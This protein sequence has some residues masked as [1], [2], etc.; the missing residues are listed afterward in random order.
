M[1]AV[2]TRSYSEPSALLKGMA[3]ALAFLAPFVILFDTARSIVTIWNSSE[4]FAH[5]YVILPIALWLVWKRRELLGAMQPRPWWPGLTL[6]AGLG[7]FWMMAELGDV[8]VV[9][10]YAL[11]A[12]VP[13]VALAMLGPRVAMAIVF[14][15][16]FVL[17]AVPF[18]EIFIDPLIDWTAAFTVA[19]LQLTGIPVLREGSNFSIPSGNW[20]VVEACSG[21]R[22][23]I[24]SFTLG[25]LYAYL[26][27]RSAYRRLL[28]VLLSI[29]VP[30]V[31]NGIRAY[32]IVMIGHLSGMQ[33]AVGVD[34]LI[35]GWLFFGLV[36]FLMFR[37]GSAWREDE[38]AAAGSTPH[39]CGPADA[40]GREDASG[41]GTAPASHFILM[42]VAVALCVGVWPGYARHAEN[43]AREAPIRLN[44]Y[45]ARWQ[46]TTPFTDWKPHFFPPRAELYRF[47]RQDGVP[48][49][50]SVMYYRQQ[51]HGRGL[52]SSLNRLVAEKDNRWSRLNASTRRE[53]VGNREFAVR[54][55]QLQGVAGSLLVWQWYWVNG[56][57]TASD[58]IGK[59]LQA[60]EQLLM[61][62][63][64]GAVLTVFAPIDGSSEK[65]R[66]AMRNFLEVNLDSL[67]N[68]LGNNAKP[69]GRTV[70]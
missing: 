11:M 57:Y 60:K 1:S 28:F 13:A 8:Q 35:Y 40:R 24:S 17:F 3:I 39:S 47:F 37:I 45:R 33:L 59:L 16:L 22:Y 4:T 41:A 20:S 26:T 65:A 10:Q 38:E 7:F 64:D 58:Y 66:T 52:I 55:A 44:E 67:E 5:G 19:A 25:C 43:G 69:E 70:Q 15:L 18:G 2:L 30:I 51:P 53:T 32:M 42:A 62:G 46:E 61:Q 29:A 23:L 34:H 56:R 36:T 21:V 14:P 12:M 9:R 48:V 6:L 54:E 49:G 63:D 31:A 27:Y 68:T 50:V